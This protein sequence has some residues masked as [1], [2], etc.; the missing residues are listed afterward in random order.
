[1]SRRAAHLASLAQRGWALTPIREGQ[2]APSDTGWLDRSFLPE[3]FAETD[4]VGVKNG[5]K[6]RWLIDTDL[7]CEEAIRAAAVL[8]PETG[9]AHGRASRRRSHL[10]YTVPEVETCKF[11][12]LD[13]AKVLI[14]VRSTGTQT[15]IPPSVYRTPE[16]DPD[17][18]EWDHN[19]DP[20]EIAAPDYLRAVRATAVATL[21]GRHW[22]GQGR[23]DAAGHLTGFLLRCGFDVPVVLRIVEVAAR[24]AG[25]DEVDDRVRYAR[26]TAQRHTNG[27]QVTGG[28]RVTE[29]FPDGTALV[30]RVF[31]WLDKKGEEALDRL[32]AKHFT[33]QLGEDTV[34]GTDVAGK[35]VRFCS[36]D[37]FRKR[38]YSAYVP[39]KGQA[40]DGKPKMSKVRLGEWWLSHPEH[41]VYEE[42]VFAPPPLDVG[43]E[44]F[45]IWQGFTLDPDPEPT[46]EMRCQRFL[47]HLYRVVCN[48]V[49]DYMAYLLDVCAL[50]IQQPGVPSGVAVVMRGDS[51][52][53]KGTFVSLFGELFGAHYKH[54]DKHEH[55]TGRFNHH[56]SGKCVLFADEAVWAGNKQEV[57]ALRRLVTERTLSIERKGI[58]VASEP[59]CVHLFMATNE[60]WVW[61]A[62]LKERRGFILDVEQKPW[63]TR[64]YFTDIYHEWHHGGAAAFLAFCQQRTVP[65]DRLGPV[66]KTAGLVTQMDLSFTT[67]QQWWLE[68]LDGGEFRIG[69]GW[70]P[71][72]STLHLFEDYLATMGDTQRWGRRTTEMQ[73]AKDLVK[74]LPPSTKK[75]RRT[76]QVNTARKG[77]PPNIEN[78]QRYGYD[79]PSL[80]ACRARFD[81]VT[82]VPREWGAPHLESGQAQPPLEDE[83]C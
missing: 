57:G 74:L 76:V 67:V 82:G 54:V 19:G 77:Q 28:G 59:N 60:D 32:N 80:D 6:S 23:H 31:Q 8:M 22:P 50:T 83:S 20:L 71:F 33:A 49:D 29:A 44:D 62:S 25:D 38:Y 37:Q 9:L 75:S 1:M 39:V 35:P 63:A 48:G 73:L 70:P 26:D 52:A 69:Q 15:V 34:V 3:D 27:R 12:D 40:K 5:V 10:W 45:N 79:L 58:D 13:N 21:F 18:L 11:L 47:D 42:A 4:N 81:A 66:P 17:P 16:G 72:I 30:R 7:D 55:V 61:P 41:R 36:F 46:P 68:K 14:E 64:D 78:V 43:A 51:G 2:K 65:G 56:L 53:G 24:I